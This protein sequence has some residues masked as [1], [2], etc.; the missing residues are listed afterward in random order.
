MV[1]TRHGGHSGD[2]LAEDSNKD[3]SG[4]RSKGASR[5]AIPDAEIKARFERHPVVVSV[6]GQM[7]APWAEPCGGRDGG[8]MP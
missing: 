6:D 5:K 8:D 1:R 7:A 3:F 4:I 2:L